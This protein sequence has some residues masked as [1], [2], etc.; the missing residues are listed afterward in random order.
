VRLLVLCQDP[1]GPVVRHRIRAILPSLEDAGFGGGIRI[2]AVPK[3]VVARQRL[4]R[5]AVDFDLV[6][7]MRKLFT[8]IDVAPLRIASRK[9]AYDFDDAVMLRDP[10]Q[11]GGRSRTREARF[12]KMM[13]RADLVLAGNSYLVA[14]AEELV[15]ER[16]PVKRAPTPID[17][18]RFAP[19][20][21]TPGPPRVGW[22]GSRSTRPYLSVISAALG[23]VLAQRPDA[24]VAVM[25]DAAPELPFD[26]EFTPWSEDAEV[27]WLQSLSVGVMPLT[28]DAWSRGKCG[29]KLLQYMACGVPAVASPVGANVVISDEGAAA[30]LAG[31]E[32]AWVSALVALLDD[33]SEA[34]ALGAAGRARVESHYAAS[35]LGPRYSYE[36]AGCARGERQ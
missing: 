34:A 26:V 28:D 24:R 19:G 11:G 23:R 17:T 29:F 16:V 13:A 25:A 20:P 36:L 32:D 7:V 6:L 1:D 35:V 30:R 22:I 15:S 18:V 8:G 12:A 2:E 14:K 3:Q 9:L 33:Q 5:S 4:L 27:P 21:R 31:D 10:F